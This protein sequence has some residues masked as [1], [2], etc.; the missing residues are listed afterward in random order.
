MTLQAVVR[1][2]ERARGQVIALLVLSILGL[3]GMAALVIDVGTW[4]VTKQRLQ[5]AA[6]QAALAAAS[7]LP[8]SP[9]AAASLAISQA[10]K[11]LSGATLQVTTSYNGDPN[12]VRIQART[13]AP[14]FFAGLLGIGSVQVGA[15]STAKAN[16][17]SGASAIFSNDTNCSQGHEL[18]IR[19]NGITETGT[20][21]ANGT[22]DIQWAG[23]HGAIT[24][25]GPNNCAPLGGTG[26]GTMDPST[27]LWPEPHQVSDFPCTYTA[28]SFNLSGAIPPG[29][30]CATG[31]GGS[32][33]ANSSATITVNTGA[34]GNVTLIAWKVSISDHNITLNPFSQNV[35]AYGTGTITAP[36][37]GAVDVNGNNMTINGTLFAPNGRVIINGNTGTTLHAFLEGKNVEIDGNAWTLTGTGASNPGSIPNLIE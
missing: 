31:G 3:L 37:S 7:A 34:T 21:H 23:A 29:V 17:G 20:V 28:N 10:H 33:G 32:P 30:Y 15:R 27:W 1:S 14:L 5:T 4:Y 2:N 35:L 24:Y 11:N 22:V 12:Q 9:D 36:G 18:L 16:P 19:V 6:D 26:G 25:G 8:G 13:A